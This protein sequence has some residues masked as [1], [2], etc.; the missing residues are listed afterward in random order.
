MK[1]YLLVF[2]TLLA[3]SA[4]QAQELSINDAVRLAQ[5][6]LNGT[7]RFRAMSGAFGALGGDLSSMNVN[8]AGSAIFSNAQVGFTLSSFNPKN[9]SNYFGSENSENYNALDLNQAGVVFVLRNHNEDSKWKKFAIAANYENTN[10]FDNSFFAAGTNPNNSIGN[11]FLGYANQGGVTLD[12]L[13]L[14]NGETID[15]LYGYLGEVYG[16]GAQQAFLGYQGYIINPVTNNPDNDTYTSNVPAGGNYYQEYSAETRGYNGKVS[17]N[18]S[19]QYDDFLS[20]GLNLNSHFTDY[21]QWS[22]IYES[23]TNDD[24]A[25]VQQMRFNNQL[26][27]LGD[28]FS[29]QLG[30]IVK[31]TE[32]LRLGVAWESPTW[33]R[34]ED[35][36]MQYVRSTSAEGGNVI[37]DPFVVNVYE[38]YRLRTPGKW[39]G[40]AAYI[41]GKRGLISADITYKDYGN[42]E[43]SPSSDY[44]DIN[45]AMSDQLTSAYQLR[46]GTEWRAK[47]WSFRGGFRS[48][49]SPYENDDVMGDLIGFSGGLGY[50]FG[51]IKL[52]L[53]YNYWQ[54]DYQQQFFAT[55]MTDAA[56]VTTK[57]HNVSMSMTF[58]F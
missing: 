24:A 9:E 30:T 43:Y 45:D 32:G 26:R 28:G 2:G 54:R 55:G 52:D 58:D 25:G 7:A 17:V 19:V 29:F 56:E 33:Y 12:L 4:I 49:S 16:F 38:D 18:G 8:P 22:S 36:L 44:R 46:I 57:N 53:A 11:Y 31:V 21:T 14:Q 37:V 5:D 50:N 6:N 15:D 34:L 10:N 3:A 40:S 42:T 1:K 23:N 48:E 51:R 39:T 27:T 41:F 47:Q 13:T 35:R 20:F